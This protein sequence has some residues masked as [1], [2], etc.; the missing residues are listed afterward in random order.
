MWIKRGGGS[1]PATIN[2]KE[3]LRKFMLSILTMLDC[4]D[5]A[6]LVTQGGTF[7]PENTARVHWIHRVNYSFHLLISRFLCV[8]TNPHQRAGFTQLGQARLCLAPR[9]SICMP[10]GTHLPNDERKWS[11]KASLAWEVHWDQEFKPIKLEDLSH[12]ARSA[13]KMN[14]GAGRGKENLR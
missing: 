10:L 13:N 8:G 2:L 9:R 4:V 11:G 5:L 12:Y 1:N 3:P 14:K 6:V 7:Q